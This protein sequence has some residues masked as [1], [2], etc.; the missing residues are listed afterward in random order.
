MSLNIEQALFVNELFKNINDI[1]LDA[2]GG[3]GKTFSLKHII[4]IIKDKGRNVKVLAPTHKAK[5]LFLKDGI[6]AETIHKFLNAKR[7]IDEETGKEYYVYSNDVNVSDISCIF[8]DESSMVSKEMFDI[9]SKLKTR[10]CYMGDR[11]QLNP[12][13]E[14][15]SPV[16]EM[17]NIHS[18]TENMRIKSNPDSLSAQY[19]KTFRELTSNPSLKIKI[20]KQNKK[21]MLDEFKKKTDCVV[22]AWTNKQVDYLNRLIRCALFNV[23]E[24]EL[25]KFYVGENLI[26]SGFYENHTNGIKY[27]SSDIITIEELK[28]KKK[29][30]PYP[31]CDC[32]IQNRDHKINRCEECGIIGHST[33]GHELTF[34][35]LKDQNGTVWYSVCTDDRNILIKILCEY[36][37]HCLVM[38]NKQTWEIYYRIKNTYD[39]NLKYSYAMTVHNS[40][41]SQFET[42]FVDI[43]NI[44]LNR[45]VEECS[46]MMYTA[47][48]RFRNSVYFI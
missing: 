18:F 6:S 8:V 10:K 39:P 38:K 1:V 12:I 41:G 34:Y 19:L 7:E 3:T 20:D 33:N 40:Q 35:E 9:I 44:K 46:R 43:N 5:S 48:S 32:G 45:N 16:F 2:P 27:Y 23:N 31:K 26:F 13:G 11:A 42:V 25:E 47:V 36:R 21:F 22:L 37:K 15:L 17:E 28:I 29:F 4:K 24:T 14:G 30:V